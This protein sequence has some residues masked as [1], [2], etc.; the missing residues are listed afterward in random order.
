MHFSPLPYLDPGSASAFF[1]ILIAALLGAGVAIVSSWSKIKTFL[2][3]KPK[4]NPEDE[5]ADDER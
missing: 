2:G 3:I 5:D 4:K 1:Q